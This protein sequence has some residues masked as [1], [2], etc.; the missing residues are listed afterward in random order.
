[1]K[2]GIVAL[3]CVLTFYFGVGKKVSMD[4]DPEMDPL[5]ANDESNYRRKLDAILRAG[6]ECHVYV[7]H[8]VPCTNPCGN[9]ANPLKKPYTDI[10][11]YKIGMTNDVVDKRVRKVIGHVHDCAIVEMV[12]TAPNCKN[13]ETALH[14]KFGRYNVERSSKISGNTEWFNVSLE[15]INNA[16]NEIGQHLAPIYG[17]EGYIV[18]YSKIKICKGV[19]GTY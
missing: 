5:F 17:E 14:A 9:L 10:D 2:T 8:E 19:K 3:L 4:I 16:I 6:G 1:M 7:I 11:I 15:L 18:D 12:L 13:F